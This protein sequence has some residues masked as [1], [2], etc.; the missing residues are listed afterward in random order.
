MTRG[1]FAGAA[2]LL[3]VAGGA[4]AQ[5]LVTAELPKAFQGRW[6]AAG[7]CDPSNDIQGGVIELGPTGLTSHDL[8]C[9]FTRIRRVDDPQNRRFALHR[10]CESGGRTIEAD[11]GLTLVDSEPLG[12]VLVAV[13]DDGSFLTLHTRCN[14]S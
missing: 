12:Q 11:I 8:T 4:A 6:L 2:A 1:F 13:N 3:L 5:E 9:T 10:T 7:T 14:G